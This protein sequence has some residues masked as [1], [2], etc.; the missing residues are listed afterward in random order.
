MFVYM[1]LA[2]Y[3]SDLLYR[4]E[5]V[6]I[7]GFGAFLTQYRS[8]KID[9]TTNTFSP[10]GKA[11]MFNRQLQ[12]N[13]GILANYVASVEN[14]SYTVALQKI[15]NFTGDLS[16]QLSEGKTVTLE[17]VGDFHLNEERTVQFKPSENGN[18]STAAFG[19][20]LL[21]HKKFSEKFIKKKWKR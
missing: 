8:A 12:T 1:Q 16:L 18:F 11:V 19:L 6:I 9:V 10:P 13:D 20:A 17:K 3:I 4:Y 5:C 21:R 15:R 2:T 7:P 14:C